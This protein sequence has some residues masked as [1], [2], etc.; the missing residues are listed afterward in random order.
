VA[1]IP[2][3][4]TCKPSRTAAVP[5]RPVRC[6]ARSATRCATANE[7][8]WRSGLLARLLRHRQLRRYANPPRHCCVGSGT[9]ASKKF[10][11][12]SSHSHGSRSDSAPRPIAALSTSRPRQRPEMRHGSRGWAHVLALGD[13]DVGM[14]VAAVADR[15]AEVHLSRIAQHTMHFVAPMPSRSLHS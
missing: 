11:W 6:P 9:M 10:G 1:E 12:Y 5:E 8:C 4:R 13:L 14:P 3:S 2:A 7:K 15:H